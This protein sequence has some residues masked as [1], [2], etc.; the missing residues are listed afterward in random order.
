M[1]SQNSHPDP[2]IDP[3]LPADVLPTS[4]V[5]AARIIPT[6]NPPIWRSAAWLVPLAALAL[7]IAIAWRAQAERGPTIR[8]FFEQ[9]HGVQP[10]DPLSLR[11]VRVGEVRRVLVSRDLSRVEVVATLTPH[12][13]GV[14]TQGTKF[15]I[16][17]PEVSLRGVT[18]LDTLLGPR[19]IECAP[20]TSNNTEDTAQRRAY[21]FEGLASPPESRLAPPGSTIIV[22]NTNNRGSLTPGTPILYRGMRVGEIHSFE[23]VPVA[24]HVRVTAVID[25]A[26]AHLIRDNV[27][28]WNASGFGVDFG[29]ISGLTLRTASLESLI[30]G[31]VAFAIPNNPGRIVSNGHE[32]EL[33]DEANPAWLRWNPA[34]TPP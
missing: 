24:T 16:V 1:Q 23:L 34:I 10:G 14:A 15:W 11:G 32:F 26:Y 21:V 9:G 13:E 33:A 22:L 20:Q 7:F 19:Y 28:F 31:G 30:T 27:R 6:R 5:P 18:G 25:P 2:T 8:I 17:R 12:A 3:A 29:V 4:P